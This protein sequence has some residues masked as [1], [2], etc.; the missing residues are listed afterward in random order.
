[1][2]PHGKLWHLS[3]LRRGLLAA[4]RAAFR[5]EGADLAGLDVED[6]RACAARSATD[7]HA[8]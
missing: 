8:P 1:V 6:N 3:L 4:C 2:K 7:P 5:A